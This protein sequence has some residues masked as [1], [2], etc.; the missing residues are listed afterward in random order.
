MTP[1]PQRVVAIQHQAFFTF[2]LQHT[3]ISHVFGTERLKR[4]R[5]VRRSRHVPISR[6]ISQVVA[7]FG[8][9]PVEVENPQIVDFPEIRRD[10]PVEIANDFTL[11]AQAFAVAQVIQIRAVDPQ[12]YGTPEERRCGFA[13]G[14][15]CLSDDRTHHGSASR[16]PR[17]SV[18]RI[19]TPDPEQ[20]CAVAGRR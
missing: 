11:T 20:R 17:P 1:P 19:D 15:R 8:Q 3:D 18:R 14:V 12:N 5:R 13:V 9:H 2:A 7:D 6:I 10:F 16:S 4:D